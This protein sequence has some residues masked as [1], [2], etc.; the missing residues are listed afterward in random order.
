MT[1]FRNCVVGK[2]HKAGWVWVSHATVCDASSP[3]HRRVYGDQC[4]CHFLPAPVQC[5]SL[6]VGVP[7]FSAP[8]VPWSSYL[9]IW[10][11]FQL[12][13]ERRQL[14]D[15]P[16]LKSGASLKPVLSLV[17]CKATVKCHHCGRPIP[18]ENSGTLQP[19]PLSLQYPTIRG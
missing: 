8:F 16:C 13:V 9:S 1:D 4:L 12:I 7:T 3:R 10:E 6:L 14:E 2:K 19:S 11:S 15:P 18:S 5:K 17:F